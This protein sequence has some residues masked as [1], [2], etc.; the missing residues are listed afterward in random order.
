M[1]EHKPEHRD[2]AADYLRDLADKVEA[3]EVEG[4]WVC[5]TAAKPEG[6]S[7]TRLSLLGPNPDHLAGARLFLLLERTRLLFL[8]Q[9]NG[10]DAFAVLDD[11]TGVPK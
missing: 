10:D 3:G 9:L 8:D 4:L 5:T 1:S 11:P 6:T 7:G 2:Q